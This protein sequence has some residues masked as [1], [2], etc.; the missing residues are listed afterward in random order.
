MSNTNYRTDS[1]NEYYLFLK[2]FSKEGFSYLTI[3]VLKQFYNCIN[4]IFD[5]TPL[6][7]D[8]RWEEV[9]NFAE[10]AICYFRLNI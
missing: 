6:P 7:G 4:D 5:Y 3:S 10:I 1:S 2:A 9:L 8:D